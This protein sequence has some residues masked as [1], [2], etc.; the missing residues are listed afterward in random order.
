MSG[1]AAVRLRPPHER[2]LEKYTKP[3]VVEP[4]QDVDGEVAVHDTDETAE[5]G[6]FGY[7][8]GT[9]D[10]AVMLEL[11]K[12]DGSIMALSYSYIER[13][14][15]DPDTGISIHALGRTIR[16]QGTNLNAPV[17]AGSNMRLFQGLTRHRVVWISESLACQTL[18]QSASTLVTSVEW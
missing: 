9:R 7:L 11:G 15:F 10:M 3:V 12:K 2:I 14:D 13:I 17:R 18:S 1:D 16:I 5:A 4:H 6:C 8:R